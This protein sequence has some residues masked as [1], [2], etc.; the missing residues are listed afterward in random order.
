[1]P[2]D[3]KRFTGES[4]RIYALLD[5]TLSDRPY[6]AGQDY[7]I[8]DIALYP[9]VE[10]HEWHGQDLNHF[11]NV[12]RWFKELSERPAVRK[13]SV[14]PWPFGEFGP[15]SAGANFKALVEKRFNDPAYQLKLD[16]N[17]LSPAE[18]LISGLSR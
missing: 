12:G 15:S 9:W 1:M 6:V 16:A 5:A 10:Y 2:F 13:G 8:A 4:R 14:V 11:P 7:T 17:H 18:A 3:I